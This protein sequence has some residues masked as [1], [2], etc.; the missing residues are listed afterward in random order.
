MEKSD[1]ARRPTNGCP[2]RPAP[3]E[4]GSG[5]GRSVPRG[6]MSTLFVLLPTSHNPHAVAGGNAADH[7]THAAAALYAADNNSHAAACLHTPDD[8]SH[9][10]AGLY[11]ADDYACAAAGLYAADHYPH[12]AAGGYGADDHP[13]A[14]AGLL[15]RSSGGRRQAGFGREVALGTGRRPRSPS[16]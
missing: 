11:A 6:G 4:P 3:A 15:R 7:H 2:R 13:N 8:N 12:A 14:A 16:R 5:D 9:A 10:A 1:V